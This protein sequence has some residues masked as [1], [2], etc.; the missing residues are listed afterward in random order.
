MRLRV[1]VTDKGVVRVRVGISV[2]V[3]LLVRRVRVYE[4][5]GTQWY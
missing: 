2:G 1:R 4:G 3:G 5:E